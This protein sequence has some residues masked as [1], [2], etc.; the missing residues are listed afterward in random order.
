[1]YDNITTFR[2]MLLIY[3]RIII[4]AIGVDLVVI[5]VY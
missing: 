4:Y 1:M 2:W 5:Y 3:L